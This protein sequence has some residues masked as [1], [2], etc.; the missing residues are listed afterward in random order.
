VDAFG[1]PLVRWHFDAGNV[2]SHGWPEQWIRTLGPR[3]AKVHVKEY[4][5]KLGDTRG[6]RAG[7][8]CELLTG[9]TD[10]PAV[11]R[12]LDD[13]GYRGWMITEQRRPPGLEGPAYLAHLAAKLDAIF[14]S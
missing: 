13:V 10:W 7:F 3:I 8:D 2:V 14:A 12:A 9:D 6:P 4:S 1:T 5:R 11:M